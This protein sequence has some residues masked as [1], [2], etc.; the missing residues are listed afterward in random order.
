[1]A[2]S[3]ALWNDRLSR[4]EIDVANTPANV[5]ELLYSSLYRASLTPVGTLV[6]Q[7]DLYYTDNHVQN[8]ATGE[9]QGAFAGTSSFYFD[10]LYC[11]YTLCLSGTLHQSH[12]TRQLG[13]LPYL[14]PPHG[15]TFPGDL[16]SNC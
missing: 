15:I 4:I 6:S 11:R 16:R 1:M 3:K 10:S 13:H 12:N 9:T 7:L 8:N 5:T 14:L 2:Q